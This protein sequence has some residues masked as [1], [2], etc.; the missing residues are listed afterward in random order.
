MNDGH[1]AA[2]ADDSLI[3]PLQQ[4][5]SRD[6]KGTISYPIIARGHVFVT[7]WRRNDVRL[8]AF[9][10]GSGRQR[11]S[12]TVPGIGDYVLAYGRGLLF[13]VTNTGLIEAFDPDKGRLVWKRALAGRNLRFEDP[14][15][16]IG[17]L[18][19]VTSMPASRCTRRSSGC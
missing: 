15:I 10:R 12:K 2:S 4:R 13:V 19:V 5:W 17:S 1:S 11:W 3:P 18:L 9:D 6:L 7:V 16:V 8:F 14:P